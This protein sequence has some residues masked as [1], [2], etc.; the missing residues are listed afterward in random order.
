MQRQQKTSLFMHCDS[1]K[2]KNTTQDRRMPEI[3]NGELF[4]G[5]GGE[6]GWGLRGN[7]SNR[8]KQVLGDFAIF[9]QK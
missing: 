7:T 5:S 6:R 1:Q 3:C 4:L 8:Q 9:L 2:K